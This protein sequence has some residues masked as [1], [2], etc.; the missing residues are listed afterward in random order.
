MRKA[1]MLTVGLAG[2]LLWATGG[3]AGGRAFF[4]V[5]VGASVDPFV[6][7]PH[8]RVFVSSGLSVPCIRAW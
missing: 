8:S 2:V 6:G 5:G 1:L 3:A 7:T 4:G